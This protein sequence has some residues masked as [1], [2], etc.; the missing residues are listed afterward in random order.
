M[1]D[2]HEATEAS[3]FPSGRYSDLFLLWQSHASIKIHFL[4]NWCPDYPIYKKECFIIYQNLIYFRPGSISSPREQRRL[5]YCLGSFS[6]QF[7][8]FLIW[9]TGPSIWRRRPTR[10]LSRRAKIWYKETRIYIYTL[11]REMNWDLTVC[12]LL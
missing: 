1:W 11:R 10:T 6:Q 4:H 8:H 7:L 3:K 5:T 9:L 2:P 12:Q